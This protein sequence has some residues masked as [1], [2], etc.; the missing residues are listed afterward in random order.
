MLALW[1]ASE[2]QAQLARCLMALLKQG[3][4]DSGMDVVWILA[5]AP[6]ILLEKVTSFGRSD[7]LVSAP[8]RC[9][10]RHK[11]DIQRYKGR[12]GFQIATLFERAA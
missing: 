9:A 1:N 2:R 11:L 8:R 7:L 12:A 3:E 5:F 6:G 10:T 4:T